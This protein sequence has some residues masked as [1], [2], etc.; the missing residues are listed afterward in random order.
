MSTWKISTALAL[1]CAI[2]ALT[3]KGAVG[4]DPLDATSST[5]IGPNVLLA[6]GATALLNGQWERGIE[7]TRLGMRMT[8]SQQDRAAAL[9]NLCAGHAALKEF[10]RA[11]ENCDRSL[12]LDAENWRTWQN[13]AAAYLGLGRIEESLRDIERGLQ[14]NPDSEALQKTLAIAREQEK[15]RQE[16]LRHLLES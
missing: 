8:I 7:L 4:A 5:V 13:R 9:S 6:D 11:L 12:A 16:R 15:L 10:Q 2:T 3:P 14:I 1:A